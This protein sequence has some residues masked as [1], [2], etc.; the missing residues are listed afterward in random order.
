MGWFWYL[1]DHEEGRRYL[2]AILAAVPTAPDHLRGGAWRSLAEVGRPSACVVH[3]SDECADAARQAA[4]ILD[5]AG[6]EHAAAMS[7]VLLAVE[8]TRDGD[9]QRWLDELDEASERFDRGSW[10]SAMADFVRMEILVRSGEA[11]SGLEAGE[12]AA[13][14]FA[15]RGDL[16]GVT[17]VRAHQ[18]AN[19]RTIGRIEESLAVS[20]QAIDVAHRIGL[21]NTVQLVSAELGLARLAIGDEAGAVQLLDQATTVARRFGYLGGEGLALV[22]HGHLARSAGDLETAITSFT[23]AT[24]LLQQVGSLPYL[25]WAHSGHGYALEAAGELVLAD[26][27]HRHVLAIARQL[28]DHGLTALALEGI[29]GSVVAADPQRAVMLLGVASR[30]RERHRR[31]GSALHAREVARIGGL[32]D[33]A[34]G[35]AWRER[36]T[37]VQQADRDDD[38]IAAL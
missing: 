20:E 4:A 28:R 33:R 12:R 6:D 13:A 24:E 25:A 7:R 19:L 16:W 3:P 23:R 30:L 32:A 36:S 11:E 31:P 22:G 29:A 15:A 38:L 34:L 26:V 9:A 14:A 5:G 10:E 37:E 17:A 2:R 35:P 8:G 18:G 1:G 27:C 21:W